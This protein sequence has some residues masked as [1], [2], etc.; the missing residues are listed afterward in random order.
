MP[1]VASGEFRAPH[2]T[3]QRGRRMHYRRTLFGLCLM[4]LA[5]GSAQAARA[6]SAQDKLVPPG[7]TAQQTQGPK[8]V[9]RYVSPDGTGMLTLRDAAADERS[10]GRAYVT[11]LQRDSDDITYRRKARSWFVL[12][13][14]RGGDIFY[15]RV[16]K[17]C[18]GRRLHVLEL[19]YPR[20]AKRKMDAEVTRLSRN[21]P[22]FQNICPK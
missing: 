9:I 13:G 19:T 7:W 2:V 14:Y 6:Q 21:L 10:I 5:L 8:N 12:S 4:A 22:R 11:M 16:D 17:A 15:T 1:A 3:V 18:G 20:A